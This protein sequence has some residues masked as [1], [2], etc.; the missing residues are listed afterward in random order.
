MESST[1]TRQPS[2]DAQSGSSTDT[3]KVA[4]RCRGLNSKE[5][6]AGAGISVTVHPVSAQHGVKRSASWMH[7]GMM[8]IAWTRGTV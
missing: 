8:Q 1:G 2:D 5:V 3:V 7:K 4:V 6:A